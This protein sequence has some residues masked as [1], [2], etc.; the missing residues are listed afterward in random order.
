VTFDAVLCRD[1]LIWI[2]PPVHTAPKLQDP[3]WEIFMDGG[4]TPTAAR[5]ARTSEE[6]IHIAIRLSL[7]AVLIYWSFVLLSPFIPILLWSVVLAVALYP[8]YDW[9]TVHLGQRPRIAAI[10]VTLAVLA[11]FLGPAAWLGIGLVEG[12][13][14]VSDQL[15]SGNL[16]IPTP[17][18]SVKSWPVIGATLHEY[19]QMASVNLESAFKEV[20]PYLK[21]LAGPV[22][23]IAGSAGTGTLMF[24]AAVVIS[25]FLFPYGPPLA[26][27]SHRALTR[28]VADRS[29]SFLALAGA[30]IRTVL[31][32]VIGVAAIQA[33]LGGIVLKIAGVP[34]ASVLAFA[35]LVLG[36][37]Q[38]GALPILIPVVIWTWMVKDPGTAVLITIFLAIVG[39]SDN[40]LKPVF[41]GRGLSTPVV[42][43]F[44]GVIGGTLAHGIV[45]LFIG[46]IILAVAWELMMAWI[47]EE[48]IP[49][50]DAKV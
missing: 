16:S 18:D 13:R 46:P 12:L 10:L 38:I 45:G 49:I 41:M 48:V 30:T 19:W 23:A 32:G 9:L 22:L 17:P 35:I 33:L 37:I 20:A 2:K 47:G 3:Q 42:V 26:A 43:I 7:L 15:I 29:E 21:P 31:Q 40:A 39:I 14:N 25:G 44:I 5:Q 1:R 50:T 6:V 28:I 24:L 34:N 8:A 4:E 36:I 27:A 11:V